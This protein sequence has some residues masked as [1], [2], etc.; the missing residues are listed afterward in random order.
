MAIVWR[1]RSMAK[2]VTS[3]SALAGCL[4][5]A[6]LKVAAASTLLFNPASGSFANFNPLPQGYG[7]RIAAADQDGFHYDLLG[8]ATPNVVTRFATGGMPGI[9]TWDFQFGDL[10]NVIYAVE[11]Q[12]FQFDLIA[13]PGFAVTL[14]SIDMASW[15]GVE[16]TINSVTI[17]DGNGS[18]LYSQGNPVIHGANATHTHFSF[19]GVTSS[20][21][22]ILFDATNLDSDDVGIDNI[23]FSQTSAPELSTF[24][25]IGIGLISLAVARSARR[26]F[27]S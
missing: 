19:N 17:E 26:T 10:Q 4:F 2:S 27:A 11:P 22:Q 13:D 16:Y 7:N 14:N 5:F 12:V 21:L 18:V 25:L 1:W 15:P 3:L 9:I 24:T 8:G 20:T 23:N 6:I